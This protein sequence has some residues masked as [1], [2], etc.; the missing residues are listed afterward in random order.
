MKLYFSAGSCSTSCHIVLEESGL[1]YEAVEVDFDN[2]SDP[3]VALVA[4]LNPLGTLPILITDE[5]KQL[6]QNLAIHTYVAD[7][8]AG[9]NLLPP[10]GTLERAETMNWMSFV[11]TD[12]HKGV[13]ALFGVSRISEDKAIQAAARTY[14]L[15]IAQGYLAYLD[16]KLAGKDYLMGK[17]FTPAD[18]YA[19]VVT[20]WTKWLEIPLTPYA[21]IPAYLARIAARPAV[22]K[23]LKDEGL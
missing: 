18:A 7:R 23:V 12:L 4:K 16:S 5:G 8:A 22:A 11:A 13:G 1:P 2:A 10:V 17:T 19:F 15:Q 14:L 3:N 21:N 6:D 20:G 9:K